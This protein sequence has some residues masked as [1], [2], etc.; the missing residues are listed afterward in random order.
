M[1]SV[2]IKYLIVFTG[3]SAACANHGI[4]DLSSYENMKDGGW[5][6][7]KIDEKQRLELPG[8][9]CDQKFNRI[10]ENDWI[11]QGWTPKEI[12][13]RFWGASRVELT[14]ANCNKDATICL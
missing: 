2:I 6:T 11:A 9:T 7:S 10:K 4:K 3:P 1:Y 5:D 14:F 8:R 12:S 13:T